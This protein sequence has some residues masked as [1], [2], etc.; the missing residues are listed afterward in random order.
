MPN[1]SCPFKH[2]PF[3]GPKA[4][5]WN[6]MNKI[7]RSHICHLQKKTRHWSI[8][9]SPWAQVLKLKTMRMWNASKALRRWGISWDFVGYL[10]SDSHRMPQVDSDEV[11]YSAKRRRRLK[12]R[13]QQRHSFLSL[14]LAACIGIPGIP[15]KMFCFKAQHTVAQLNAL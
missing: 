14:Q 15:Q 9:Q 8:R 11:V 13:R 2:M 1:F 5:I 10:I 6:N 4:R 3:S 12:K 7:I